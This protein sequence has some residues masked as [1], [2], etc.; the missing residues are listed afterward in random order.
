MGF[1]FS[2]ITGIALNSVTLYA[3]TKF[4]DGVTYT[5]GFMFF[6]I[7]GAVIGLLNFILKPLLKLAVF[8]ILII[9]GGLFFMIVNGILL[10][11]LSYVLNFLHISGVSITFP[12]IGAYVIGAIVFGIVNWLVNLLK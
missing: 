5:G 6:I 11:S 2:L 4:V 10:W 9:S 12:N 8:P 3:I 1:I 7:G